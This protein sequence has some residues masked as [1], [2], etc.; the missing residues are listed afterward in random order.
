LPYFQITISYIS[1][2]LLKLIWNCSTKI[3]MEFQLFSKTIKLQK[4][5]KKKTTQSDGGS[6]HPFTPP[7]FRGE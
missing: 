2:F 3:N 1:I 4:K 6:L 5:K 7:L